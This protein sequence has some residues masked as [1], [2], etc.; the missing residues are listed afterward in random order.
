MKE[1]NL[2]EEKIAAIKKLAA[3]RLARASPRHDVGT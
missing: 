3:C 2:I 1:E